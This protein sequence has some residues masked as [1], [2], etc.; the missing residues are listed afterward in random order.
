MSL[1]LRRCIL[2]AVI[3][4]VGGCAGGPSLVDTDGRRKLPSSPY[5][6][7]RCTLDVGL[8]PATHRLEATATLTVAL[9]D[10]APRAASG[11]LLLQLHHDLG[12][13]GITCGEAPVSFRRLPAIERPTDED[14]ASE[15][16][17]E[18]A[19]PAVYQIDWRAP[20]ARGAALVIRYGGRLYQDVEAGEKPGEIHNFQMNAHI[21]KE[22]IYLGEDGAWY[23]Q[24]PNSDEDE[25]SEE[26]PLTDFE[27]TVTE[28]PGMVLVACGN[29]D[30]AKLD[31][32]RGKRTTWRNPFP[33][34]GMALVGGSHQV[35][36]QQV[37]DVLVSVHV[38]E[39]HASFAPRILEAIASYLELYQPLI[40]KYPYIEFTVVENF[41]SSG[42][43]F[44]GFTVMASAVIDMGPRCLL[45]GFFDHEM[46]HNW[47]G[48]GVFVSALDGNWCESITSYCAN[49]MRHVLED[50]HEKARD[51]RRNTCYMLSRIK[52]DKDRPLGTYGKDDGCDRGIAYDKGAMVFAMLADTVGQDTLWRAFR[53]FYHEHLGKP[54]TWDDIRQAVERESGRSLQAFFDKWV[55]DTGVPDIVIDEA[56]YDQRA[57]RLTMT[58]LQKGE[59][60]FDVTVPVRL[61]YD[62][63]IVDETIQLSRP[64]QVA[65]I[66]SL[67]APEYVELDP[68]FHV[69]HRVPLRDVMPTIS[70]IGKSKDLVIVRSEEDGDAYAAVADGLTGRY[71][72]AEDT[73]V[74]AVKG[75]ELTAEDLKEGHALLLGKACLTPAAQEVLKDKPLSIGD[76]FFSVNDKRYDNPGNEVLCCVRNERDPG[77]VICF[78]YG[79]SAEH[80]KKA[81]VV[82][83]YGGNSLV[84]FEDGRVVQRE[85]F[86]KI[87][88]VMVKDEG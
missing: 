9:K 76:G 37:G 5:V 36:Q 64:A 45:P 78:Y 79:N 47:W 21:S 17:E 49:Y 65:V 32:P 44:P 6:I 30:G 41:F 27:L 57:R 42:F 25:P 73:T 22:G 48:N 56:R 75:S 39:R 10:K 18:G 1:V 77:G 70:G 11:K 35:F 19:P 14:G 58:A 15:A 23:P 34:Q 38:L 67:T 63:G 61:V 74:R 88:R 66:K 46:I 60:V 50:R 81:R 2:L 85:D 20:N 87:E 16:S 53:R 3:V 8:E 52:P 86:E 24:L 80:L 68:D 28:V 82:T 12:I 83:F 4:F 59:D 40:G 84:V 69:M 71:E 54:A 62:D 51:K 26:A 43:A 13:D 72:K 33:F 55:R 31:T 29:R 7:E